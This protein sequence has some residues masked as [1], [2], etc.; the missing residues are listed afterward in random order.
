MHNK[1]FIFDLDGVIVDTAKYHYLAWK[2]LADELGIPFTKEQNEQFKGVSR[3]RCLEILLDWGNIKVS[4]EQFDQWLAEK[5]QDYLQYI[6][7][8]TEDEIL[9]DV[10]KVLNFLRDHRVPMALG[11]ASKNAQPILKK[12]GLIPYFNSIVDG[13]QVR[14]AKPNPEVF[15]IAASN[16]DI[17]PENCVVFE[18][19][20]AGIEAANSAG[21]T[22]VGI[23]NKNTLSN[24]QYIF[25]DF[26]EIDLNFIK[27]LAEL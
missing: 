12:V 15:F 23:G 20:I 25:K 3:K 13:T 10:T 17:D 27:K 2:H 16:L 5:N 1:G 19:A 6:E 21:M 26:T 4:Q 24:A 11:S 8:M 18:D 22:S 14:K 7:T 9:P